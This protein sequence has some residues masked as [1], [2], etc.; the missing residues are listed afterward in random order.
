MQTISVLGLGEV[1]TGKIFS[2]EFPAPSTK[3]SSSCS[4]RE[5]GKSFGDRK[6]RSN[7]PTRT[8][9]FPLRKESHRQKSPTKEMESQNHSFSHAKSGPNPRKPRGKMDTLERGSED[10]PLPKDCLCLFFHQVPSEKSPP[11]LFS[12]PN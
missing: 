3:P 2:A 6:R 1:R 10:N 12:K 8:R 5:H 4:L 7:S 9:H 11:R